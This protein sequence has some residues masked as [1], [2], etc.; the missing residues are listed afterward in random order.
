MKK[1]YFQTIFP[2]G[3]PDTAKLGATPQKI[4]NRHQT[5][6]DF[7]LLRFSLIEIRPVDQIPKNP[8]E[9]KIKAKRIP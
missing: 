8:T 4:G 5:K 7:H 2:G 3:K 9:F 1:F 6:S